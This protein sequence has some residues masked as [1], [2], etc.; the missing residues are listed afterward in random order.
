MHK[1]SKNAQD[2]TKK[3]KIK[4]PK[5]YSSLKAREEKNLDEDLAETFP[6]SDPVTKY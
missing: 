3:S 2:G 5:R 1:K 4:N 6:A